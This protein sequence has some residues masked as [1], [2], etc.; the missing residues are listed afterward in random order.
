MN[1]LEKLIDASDINCLEI[2]TTINLTGNAIY[3]CQMV[4][5]TSSN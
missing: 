4:L 3:F 1:P 2:A 5:A